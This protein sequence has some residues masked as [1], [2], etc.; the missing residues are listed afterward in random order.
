MEEEQVNESVK[1]PV[2]VNTFALPNEPT[3]LRVQEVYRPSDHTRNLASEKGSTVYPELFIENYKLGTLVDLC[4]GALAHHFGPTPLPIIASKPNLLAIHYD[5][6][7]LDMPL[8]DCYHISADR[9][10]KR[11]VLAKHPDKFLALQQ[12][13]Q[14]KK[15][16]VSLKFVEMVEACPAEYW[17]EEEMKVLALKIKD[18]VHELH[19]KH[20]QSLQEHSF[21]KYIRLE[22]ETSSDESEE[23]SEEEDDS[24]SSVPTSVDEEQGEEE[25]EAEAEDEFN[26]TE[27][28]LEFEREQARKKAYR[29]RIRQEIRDAKSKET[30]EREARRQ[31]RAAIR[32]KK[33]VKE[34]TIVKKIPKNPTDIFEIPIV[35]SED[36]GEDQIVDKRNKALFLDHLKNYNYPAEH[37]HHID[38]RFVQYFSN[39]ETFIIEFWGP[40]QQRNY[41]LRHRNF[42][43]QDIK[44]LA[45]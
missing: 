11:F 30:A 19:I 17:P 40:L 18:D 37:C 32:A 16:G 3:L 33:A 14:W 44:H 23:E 41:H 9:F 21:E 36:D 29:K 6:L 25:E 35:E 38:L 7:D 27:S 10:W 5:A 26:K 34:E 24:E 39:L 12:D 8:A 13:V 42:S 43:L 15:L 45:M 31:K 20:L 1:Y 28:Q 2:H 4:V 22:S